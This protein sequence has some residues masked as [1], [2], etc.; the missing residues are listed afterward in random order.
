[1]SY[2]QAGQWP[3]GFQ[4]EIS[5]QGIG[6]TWTVTLTFGGGQTVSQLWGGSYTQTGNRVTITNAAWNGT[7]PA[8]AGFIGTWT[9]SNPPP[10]ASCTTA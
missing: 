9:G 2:R 6:R 1:V 3:G 5:V 8:T 4:G 10:T 7:P